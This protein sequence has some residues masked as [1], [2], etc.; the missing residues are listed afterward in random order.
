MRHCADHACGCATRKLRVGVK[1]DDV[2]DTLQS[3]QWACFYRKAV[4]LTEQIIIEIEQLAAFSLPSHPD[5][6]A[7]VEDAMPM[8]EEERAAFFIAVFGVQI[9]DAL[10]RQGCQGV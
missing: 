2:A 6:L 3:L 8:Q 5:P 7:G 1:R 9:V 4:V 10:H